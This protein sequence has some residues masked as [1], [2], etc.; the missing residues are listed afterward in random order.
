MKKQL[1][2][3]EVSAMRER[4]GGGELDIRDLGYQRG[5]QIYD[6]TLN[7]KF[8]LRDP[9]TM[10]DQFGEMVDPFKGYH[11]TRA[12]RDMHLSLNESARMLFVNFTRQNEGNQMA[13]VEPS[14]PTRARHLMITVQYHHGEIPGDKRVR[15]LLKS[16]VR[17]YSRNG[18]E[19][20]SDTE[21]NGQIAGLTLRGYPKNQQAN[22]PQT[23]QMVE[24]VFI[25]PIGYQSPRMTDEEN[26][27]DASDAYRVEC[28]NLLRLQEKQMHDDYARREALARSRANR[29]R[30]LDA[31]ESFRDRI[32]NG[33]DGSLTCDPEKVIIRIPHPNEPDFGWE[34]L[35][36]L[37]G[38]Q[39]C[40]M[41]L[42]REEGLMAA[43][44]LKLNRIVEDNI[45]MSGKAVAMRQYIANSKANLSGII[46]TYVISA[47]GERRESDVLYNGKEMW[48]YIFPSDLILLHKCDG[49]TQKH[50]CE[51][52][53]MPLEDCLTREQIKAV[54]KLE[55]ELGISKGWEW[56]QSEKDAEPSRPLEDAT[57]SRVEGHTL[58]A[59][60]SEKATKARGPKL[61]VAAAY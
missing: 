50:K 13:I 56:N 48:Y 4:A 33:L 49:M 46:Q 41:A 60:A 34:H 36:G 10:V 35:Y 53:K 42:Q 6:G 3:A 27:Q 7:L 5:I 57:E 47:N 18:Y 30:Y 17:F 19:A 58:A 38:V 14:D 32:E 16:G 28:A 40:N 26:S 52:K 15:L 51:I 22:D 21:N 44:K 39:E 25:V 54:R 2:V 61:E 29:A 45:L 11:L 12:T 37:S 23:V 55:R 43:L 8:M 9:I 24:D 20:T 1:T 59:T 31:F